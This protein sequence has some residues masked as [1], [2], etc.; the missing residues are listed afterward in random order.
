MINMDQIR[1]AKWLVSI[2]VPVFNIQEYVEVCIR[3]IMCQTY[4]NIQIIIVD[5]G[6]EDDS[7][8]IC[9]NIGKED[10]R[11][12][13]IHKQNG[14][15]SDA[16][17]Y[18]LKYAEGDFICFVDGDDAIDENF[19]SIMMDKIIKCKADIAVTNYISFK[20]F[21]P[22]KEV[23]NSIYENWS[24]DRLIKEMLV[25]IN[26]DHTAW[27]KIYKKELWNNVKFPKGKI[28]EDYLSIYKIAEK[29]EKVVWIEQPLYYYRQRVGSIIKSKIDENKLSIVKV[30]SDVTNDI[31]NYSK[32]L[33][34]YAIYRQT[35]IY[36]KIMYEILEVGEYAF[37]S[38]QLEIMEIIKSNMRIFLE[39]PVT[40]SVDKLR[41]KLLIKNR[42]LFVLSY[43]I[44]NFM[45]ELK[46]K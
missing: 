17:N 11:I 45:K 5:D 20:T 14:G 41:L 38:Y 2:I 33:S 24:S 25:S 6:S 26:C 35:I 1:D 15:L 7:G 43:R 16:R 39:C 32:N 40:R 4:L 23:K 9:E 12:I 13:V 27:G 36:I 42:R 19:I 8:R 21:P 22:Q 18:G 30:A 3:S 10:N 29:S 31:C 46:M 44:S 37:K 34:K 28:Y